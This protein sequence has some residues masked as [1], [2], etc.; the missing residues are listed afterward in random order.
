MKPG[1]NLVVLCARLLAATLLLA[2]PA[3]AD[4]R[5]VF[6]SSGGSFIYDS[7][8]FEDGGNVSVAALRSFSG[9]FIDVFFWKYR[10]SAGELRL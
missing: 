6:N 8:S 4:I 9:D 3:R 10:H 7:S 5:Y 1:L 2:A